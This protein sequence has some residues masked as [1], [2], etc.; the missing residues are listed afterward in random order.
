MLKCCLYGDAPSIILPGPPACPPAPPPT[1]PHPSPRPDVRSL[2]QPASNPPPT[3]LKPTNPD[4]LKTVEAALG[5]DLGDL[6]RDLA[7]IIY[8]RDS[9]PAKARAPPH[10]HPP[11]NS[12]DPCRAHPARAGAAPVRPSVSPSARPH[13]PGRGPQA[14][15]QAEMVERPSMELLYS[16][17][18]VCKRRAA[19]DGVAYVLR[20][21][22]AY[23]VDDVRLYCACIRRGGRRADLTIL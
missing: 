4:L 11:P 16:L 3:R 5:P 15:Q 19:A 2:L 1:P 7:A 23:G 9:Q 14:A 20:H 17:A 22:E 18:D 10:P 13:S 21:A 8:S 6:S 12:S